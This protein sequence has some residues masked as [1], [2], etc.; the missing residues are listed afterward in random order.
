MLCHAGPEQTDHTVN[1][2]HGLKIGS[3]EFEFPTPD[4]A[5]EPTGIS[6]MVTGISLAEEVEEPAQDGVEVE[7]RNFAILDD[8][9]TPWNDAQVGSPRAVAFQDNGIYNIGV[10]PTAEDIGRGGP[11]P[12]GW[13]LSLAALALKNLGGPNYEPCDNPMEADLQNCAL[14]GFDPDAD[15]LGLFEVTGADQSINPGLEMEPA[16]PLLPDHLAEFVNNLPAGELSPLIDELAFAPNTVGA[17]PTQ[18]DGLPF[19]LDF[20]DAVQPSAEFGEILFGADLH[21][22]T[23]DTTQFGNQPPNFGWGPLCPNSQTGVPVNFDPPRQGTEPFEN[24]LARDGAIKVPQLRNVELTGPYF[25]TGSYLTLRQVVDFYDRGGDFPI[26]NSEDRD[27]NLVDFDVHAFSFGA[28]TGLPAQFQ[29]AV[30]DAVTL[31]DAMPDTDQATT[32]EPATSTPEQAKVA[33]VKFLLALTD[34]RVAHEQAPFDRPEIFVPLDGTAPDNTFGRD[35]LLALSV[36]ECSDTAPVAGPGPCFRHLPAVG[37]A[38]HERL[39]NFLNVASVEQGGVCDHF[40]SG[41]A[42]CGNEPPVPPEPALQGFQVALGLDFTITQGLQLGRRFGSPAN[43]RS[44]RMP[45]ITLSVDAQALVRD[46]QGAA[47]VSA[48]WTPGTG[49]RVSPRQGPKA[50][51]Q[52]RGCN[53]QS[54]VNVSSSEGSRQ[55]Q[56]TTICENGTIQAEITQ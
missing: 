3:T 37:A 16:I 5:P 21:C 19:P 24:R 33:L 30:P 2:D 52:I 35:G 55:L 17:L 38:G 41:N 1:A 47:E 6:K 42:D 39:S 10:R 36:G 43:F 22:G 18:I 45:G 56:I 13:P 44:A 46:D 31:Y 53:L 15:D 54:S 8:P 25:R 4:T 34:E 11:D 20:G 26:T 40:D 28:T 12:F 51:L 48:T 23:F 9:A 27:P 49:V 7:N 32:P 50:R 14:P 29:D